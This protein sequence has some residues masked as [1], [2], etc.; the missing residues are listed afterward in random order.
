MPA[1][2]VRKNKF[3]N[4]I[5]RKFSN[6]NACKRPASWARVMADGHSA[7]TAAFCRCS[8]LHMHQEVLTR[9]ANLSPGIPAT[10]CLE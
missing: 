6:L 3:S 4:N 1:D 7:W 8:G 2:A 9:V 5:D 10:C